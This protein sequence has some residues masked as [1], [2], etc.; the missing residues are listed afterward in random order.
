[1]RV[2][3]DSLEVLFY[4]HRRNRSAMKFT[5]A[6]ALKSFSLA[7]D[8]RQ[9]RVQRIHDLAFLQLLFGLDTH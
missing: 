3:G 7:Q 9:D 5:L 1:M 2:L 6:L 4:A 8:L